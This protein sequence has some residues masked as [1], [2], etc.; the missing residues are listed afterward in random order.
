MKI[1]KRYGKDDL[2]ILYVA[3]NEGKIIEFVESLQPPVPRNQKWVL[4]ISTLYGCPMKCLIC[5]TGK[6]YLGPISSK[7]LLEQI[8]FLIRMRFPE[9]KISIPKFKIQFARMGEPTL[10]P[11]VLEVMKQ[12]PQIYHAPG[13]MPCIS[14]VAPK[15]AANFLEDLISIKNQ[16]YSGG[17]FQLQFSIHSSEESVRRQWIPNE[18]WSLQDIRNYGVRWY[19]KGDRKITLNFAVSESSIIDPNKIAQIFDTE[20]FFIKITPVNPT[21]CAIE[22][23]IQS[24]ITQ[25]NE[26]IFPLAEQFRQLGFETLISIGD[27]EENQIGTNCG[28]FASEYVMGNAE[29]KK[30]YTTANYELE[31]KNLCDTR[32]RKETK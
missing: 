16:L 4:I 27:W 22:N 29:I 18:I 30:N 2:A 10:N 11:A 19:S 5:D 8:D 17:H 7:E 12:L 13:L 25:K 31:I 28:Q 1:L 6:Q 20:R 14:T 15:C 9:R 26:K 24:A 3:E 32:I 21:S 23:K